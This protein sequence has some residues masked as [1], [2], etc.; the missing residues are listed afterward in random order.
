HAAD[1]D[2]PVPCREGQ[3]LVPGPLPRLTHEAGNRQRPLLER[4]AGGGPGGE[5]GEIR[6]EVLTRRYAV[7]DVAFRPRRRPSPDEAA[8]DEALGH[9]GPPPL[10]VLATDIL[11]L[12]EALGRPCLEFVNEPS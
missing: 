1:V 4:R 6:R 12:S 3:E 10:P 8:R 7:A 5:H 2:R 9:P 11:A